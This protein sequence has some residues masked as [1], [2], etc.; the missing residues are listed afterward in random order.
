MSEITPRERVLQAIAH[1]RPDR[2]P[3]HFTFTSPAR[4]RLLAHLGDVDLERALGNHLAIYS[5][6]QHAG[7]EEIRPGYWRDEFGVVW[8]RTTDRDVGIVDSYLLPSRSLAG[9]SFPDPL[10]PRRFAALAAFVEANRDRFRVASIGF[11]LFERAWSLRSMPELLIDMM[12]A[13]EWVDEL[14]GAIAAFQVATVEQL[15]RYDL[16]AVMFGD[17]WGQQRGLLMGPRLWRRFIKPHL[18]KMYGAVKRA[19]RAVFI[20]SCGCVQ[21]LFPELVELG[22]DVFNPFQPEAMDPYEIKRQFGDVLS[23]YGGVSVQHLLPHGM[24]REI[25]REVR[26]LM[27]EIGRDGGYIIGPSH[28]VP[29]D[30]PLENMLALIEAVQ[31]GV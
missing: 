15:M 23:F 24:P 25:R 9:F 28:D 13:P 11:S 29:A 7:L 27:A 16:D 3:Y 12:E 19:G 5:V 20:H 2:V 8:N 22:L 18:A 10:S 26:R 21:E 17:D 4:E 30:V 14:L 1:R 31:E 6:R